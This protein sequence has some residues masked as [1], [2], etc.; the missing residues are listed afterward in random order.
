[1]WK[2]LLYEFW[3]DRHLQRT[4]VLLTCLGIACGTFIVVVLLALG[5]GIKRA[6]MRELLGAYDAAIVIYPGMT[7]QPYQGL[8]SRRF[9]RF[10]DGDADLLL[11]EV[12]DIELASKVYSDYQ[13]RLTVEGSR[14]N[15]EA[16]L[17]GV[18]PSYAQLRNINA[19][20]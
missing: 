19:A 12:R 14:V 18:D 3:A 10:E 13:V 5:E 17:R 2:I 15:E 9:I 4:R 16:Q 7:T 6:V 11:R 1:M 8:P 20:H